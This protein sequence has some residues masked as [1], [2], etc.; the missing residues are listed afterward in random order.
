VAP[1][2]A[3]TKSRLVSVNLGI[4]GWST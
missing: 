2:S 1:Y 4:P 3:Y